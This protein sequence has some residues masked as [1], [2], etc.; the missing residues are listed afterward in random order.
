MDE[1][2]G[3]IAALH[4]GVIDDDHWLAALDRLSDAFGGCAIFLGTTQRSGSA[5]ELSGHRVD[6]QW[7]ELVNGEL[8]GDES[9]PVFAAVR[10]NFRRDPIGMAMQP[11]IMSRLLDRDTFHS[12]PIYRHA[13]APAGHEHAMAMVLW[14]DTTSAI[15]LTLVRP[16]RAGDFNDRE[17]EVARAV[18]PHILGALKLR[19][20]FA[21]A[22]SSALM[23]DRFDHG[24]L[25]LSAAGHVIH[26]NSEA[27]RMLAARDGL[28]VDHGNLHAAFPDDTRRLKQMLSEADRAARGAS[29]QPRQTLR[30]PRADRRAD[31]VIRVLPVAPVVASSFGAGE[32]ATI[33][34]FIHDP[35]RGAQPVEELIAE[36][37]GLSQ[38]EA[39]VAARIWDGE[40]VSQA[41]HGLGVSPNT[42]KTHLKAIF[43]KTGVERQ[44]GLVRRIA[45]MLAAMGQR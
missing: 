40:S 45:Q 24:V 10:N 21:L 41:A 23:L 38:A 36:G 30:L 18:G 29:L 3:L 43:E 20:Q 31:L 2:L 27:E 4:E 44:A 13:I 22:R 15:S 11:M 6:P 7:I 16:E 14:A 37:L 8:A 35:D 5:F 12:S 33:A 28:S 9:N 26:A 25:L 34:L 17:A 19:H 1:L 42:V 39:A 32:L